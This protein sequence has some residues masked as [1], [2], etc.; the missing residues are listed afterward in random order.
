MCD[1][2]DIIVGEVLEQR[3]EKLLHVIY[4]ASHMLNPAQMNYA[5]TKKELLVV[6]YA[7]DKFR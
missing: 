7:F 5:T 1:V 4:Y 2:S 3:R 6:V